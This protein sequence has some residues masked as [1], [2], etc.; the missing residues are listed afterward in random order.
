MKRAFLTPGFPQFVVLPSGESHPVRAWTGGGYPGPGF[1][2]TQAFRRIRSA[3]FRDQ[4]VGWRCFWGDSPNR[5]TRRL[6]WK[7]A[8]ADAYAT[9]GLN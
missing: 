1:T 8:N 3:L 9:L 4:L 5:D 7:R 6:F 2:P